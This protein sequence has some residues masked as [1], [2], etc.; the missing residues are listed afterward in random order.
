M[1]WSTITEAKLLVQAISGVELAALRA[2]ALGSG[3]VDPVQPSI[4][5]VT[6]E[7]RG[8]VAACKQNTL[9]ADTAK[10]PDRLMA[11][12]CMMVAVAIIGR[13]PGYDLDE[14]KKAALENALRL[15]RYTATCEFAI[16]DPVSGDESSPRPDI[17][18]RG[19]DFTRDTQDGI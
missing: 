13:V 16:E 18:E 17:G 6:G 9:D 15:M 2:A 12:A 11:A 7:V 1:S 8:Y 19:R 5:Q 10:I 4:D 14:K 3:Q